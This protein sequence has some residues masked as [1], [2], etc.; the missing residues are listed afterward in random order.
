MEKRRSSSYNE[1]YMYLEEGKTLYDLLERYTGET[2]FSAAGIFNSFRRELNLQQ[3]DIGENGQNRFR[4]FANSYNRAVYGQIVESM[5]KNMTR[6]EKDELLKKLQAVNPEKYDFPGITEYI[7]F[8]EDANFTSQALILDR[9]DDNTPPV[10]N[11]DI[12][13]LNKILVDTA[14]SKANPEIVEKLRN[15]IIHTALIPYAQKQILKSNPET[16]E[17]QNP[18]LHEIRFFK[19]IFFDSE[20]VREYD[21]V[22]EDMK[23]SGREAK[24]KAELEEN[25]KYRRL[26]A[27]SNLTGKPMSELLAKLKSKDEFLIDAITTPNEEGQSKKQPKEG[28]YYWRFIPEKKPQIILNEDVEFS[29]DGVENQKIIVASHGKFS[30]GKN[31]GKSTFSDMPL[32]VIGVTTFGKDINKNYFLLTSRGNIANMFNKKNMEYYKKVLLS[33][34]ILED[35]VAQKDSFLPSIFLDENGNASLGYED[36]GRLIDLDPVEAVKY[37]QK[38]PGLIGPGGKSSTLVKFFSSN[39]LFEDQMKLL[40]E[41]REK[42]EQKRMRNTS[43]ER[44]EY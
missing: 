13:E 22:L 27:L 8:L 41:I 9:N 30:Y 43:R 16:D 12:E 28:D 14:C 33:Q 29:K 20:A 38:F 17:S 26:S 5:E 2:D 24:R 10:L 44:G 40:V 4:G 39:E 6:E 34:F 25:C 32:E 42:E 19:K 18:E 23:E 36:D 1:M 7:N 31:I 35:V 15:M 37:A 3:N 21:T 11:P